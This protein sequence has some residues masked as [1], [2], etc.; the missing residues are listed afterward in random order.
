ML[1]PNCSDRLKLWKLD[2][3]VVSNATPF[4]L[5]KKRSKAIM[6]RL[7]GEIDNHKAW[8]HTMESYLSR[9]KFQSY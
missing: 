1:S 6:P 9:L 4:V 7:A 3:P 2:G 5:T 8:K